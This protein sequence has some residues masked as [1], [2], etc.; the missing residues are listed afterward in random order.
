[1]AGIGFA[2]GLKTAWFEYSAE[3][4]RAKMPINYDIIKEIH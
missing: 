4:Q 3:Q 2:F 1:M